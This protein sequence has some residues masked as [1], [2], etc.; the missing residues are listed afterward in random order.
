MKKKLTCIVLVVC[1]IL[2]CFITGSVSISAA[3]TTK[4]SASSGSVEPQKKIQGAA[5]L[6]CFDWSYNSIKNN[7]AAIKAAGYT[8]VQTSPV[9]PAKDYNA[10]Y[11]EQSREWWKL[12]QPLGIRISE[13]N[14]TWL[15]GKSELKA[16]CTEAHK[17]GIKVVVDVVANHVAN[18]SDG[19]GAWNV[20]EGVD[21]E[22]KRNDY[23]HGE[24]YGAGDGDRYSMTHGHIG[25]PDLNT[26]HPD[27]QDKFK[28]FLI[29]CVNQGVDGFRFDA[30]KHIE[31][32]EDG[33]NTGSQFWPT[34]LNGAKSKKSDAFF[35]G[36]I[37]NGAGTNIGNYTKYMS[38]TDNNTGD[39]ILNA[40][41]NGNAQGAADSSYHKGGTA[42]KAVLWAES[43][44]TYMGN[45]G[46]GGISNTKNV[47]NDKIIRTW[48]MIGSRANSSALYFA[49]PAA[50][51]GDASSDTTWKSAAVAE[52]NK[53]KN[54]FD[55]ES[56]Y[57]ASEGDVAYNERGTTGV[58]IAK[59]NG[60]G[61]VS[62]TAHKMKDGTYKDAVSGGTFTVSGGI[63]S[64][65]VGSSGVA[66][67]YSAQPAGPSVS[68]DYNG[69]NKGGDFFGTATITLNA[70][71]TK[72]QTYKLGSGAETPYTNGKTI[73]IG[74][75]MAEEQSVTLVLKG[76]GS[77]GKTVTA[78]YVFKKNKQPS[79]NGNTVVYYDNSA[80]NWPT[81]YCYAYQGDGTPN[82]G[83]WPGK[84]MTKISDTLWG[85]AIDD[86]WPS[87]QVIFSN[88]GSDQ[89]TKE[90]HPVN[91]GEW[92]I[93]QGGAW[94][95]YPKPAVTPTQAPT[96]A[97][98]QTTAYIPPTPTGSGIY[99][100]V[101]SDSIISVKDASAIQKHLAKLS[102]LTGDNLA[103]ADANGDNIVNIKDATIV[104]KYIAK[105][106]DTGRVGQKYGSSTPVVTPTQ[107]PTQ[108]PVITDPP[109]VPPTEAPKG[110]VVYFNN[111][112]NWA[113]VNVYF[114][115][116]GEE[117][118]NAWPGVAMEKGSDGRYK[119]TIPEGY[120][121]VIFNNGAGGSGNQT[122]NIDVENNKEYNYNSYPS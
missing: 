5:I 77:D 104:Q 27:I 70:S 120:D 102:K 50:N 108:A 32:P 122:A 100:D 21:S 119:Y 55:G 81:V 22:L 36:E 12:Y 66:V 49:R 89:D 10:S 16:M 93:A 111:D 20:N 118:P 39:S 71:S 88:N 13:S 51:M 110:N 40:V 2:T 97:P 115:K 85:Y 9:Q 72:S 68:I 74:A 48:A 35:Y 94:K 121:K 99:G 91:S 56:E 17:Y 82:N 107:A 63:I 109:T 7:M 41:C 3:E 112:V 87:A 101:N 80:T 42:D 38:I 29:D 33:G 84:A 96:A 79:M 60:S 114:W 52:V 95:D 58:V 54:Y 62:L 64:G 1:M 23:Y 92:K 4:K 78:Q 30:A 103:K 98:Q 46:S 67:V 65:S 18:K 113:N 19:G 45:S 69:A 73:T 25:M 90:G 34:I 57:V 76:V 47:S 59:M 43:H 105:L 83:E 116:D 8:A 37:L 24:E 15:G 6:H 44:D 53:F 106:S 11:R 117:G 86:S 61:S 14:Q 75:D 28:N 26:A 31:L